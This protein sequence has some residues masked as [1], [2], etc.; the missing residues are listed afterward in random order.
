MVIPIIRRQ[1]MGAPLILLI[2]PRAMGVLMA[3]LKG[4]TLH[5]ALLQV[6]DITPIALLTVHKEDPT[7]LRRDPLVLLN[8]DHARDPM[9]LVRIILHL[10]AKEQVGCINILP[11][12][13]MK[14]LFSK[15]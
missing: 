3:L 8:Q 14:R 1:V 5:I 12:F 15:L 13:L 6:P 7:V 4:A 10:R 9:D 2:R 11:T